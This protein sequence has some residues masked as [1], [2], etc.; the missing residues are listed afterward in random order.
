MTNRKQSHLQ[1]KP[2]APRLVHNIGFGLD[3]YGTRFFKVTLEFERAPCAMF[4]V[5]AECEGDIRARLG[6]LAP[7]VQRE[8]VTKI[9]IKECGQFQAVL[10]G[11]Y[12]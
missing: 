11:H 8:T 4:K 10:T 9:S 6:A 5:Q 12:A 7:R 2:F 1:A 3:A